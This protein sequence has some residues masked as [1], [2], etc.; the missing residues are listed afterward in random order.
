MV[1]LL[2]AGGD[3]GAGGGI[4]LPPSLPPRGGAWTFLV[5]VPDS[6]APGRPGVVAGGDTLWAGRPL[7]TAADATLWEIDLPELR[8]GEPPAPAVLRAGGEILLLDPLE[9]R[10]P[11]SPPDSLLLP[12]RIEAVVRPGVLLYPVGRPR[13]PLIEVGIASLPLADLLDRLDVVGVEKAAWSAAEE[14]SAIVVGPEQTTVEIPSAVR[15]TYR[16]L[17]GSA[18]HS[19]EAIARIL[20]TAAEIDEA[21]PALREGPTER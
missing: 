17:L 12:D 20:A 3:A 5:S 4:I 14:E 13:V 19:P 6:L 11:P 21:R 8:M 9:I 7:P 1:L 18:G 15:R 10:M 16:F 2:A